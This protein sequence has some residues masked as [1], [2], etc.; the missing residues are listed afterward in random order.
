MRWSDF[1]DYVKKHDS[2]VNPA[3]FAKRAAF[4][5]TCDSL[6]YQYRTGT[7]D[8]KTIYNVGSTWILS[9]WVK[10]KPIIEH[11]RKWEWQSNA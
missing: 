9:C 8:L 3:N 11:Y 2:A 1:E 4:W 7:I 5:Q 10:F 6:D